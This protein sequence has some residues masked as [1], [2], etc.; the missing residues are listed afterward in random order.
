MDRIARAERLELVAD[1]LLEN[2][3]L[4]D[5]LAR[6]GLVTP[7]GSYVYG[8]MT[9]RDIDL[10][11][12]L[13]P[14]ELPVV[15]EIGR[16]IAALPGVGSML[17]RNEHVLETEGNPHAMF[18]R[19]TVRG[20][21]EADWTVEVLIAAPDEVARVVAPGER[22]VSE[23]TPESRAAILE[24]KSDPAY[25]VEFGSRDVHEAVLHHGLGSVE[26]L[27]A[28]WEGRRPGR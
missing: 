20:P 17:F 11:L 28:W 22:L 3:G 15:F 7:T 13:D 2:T 25:R 27:R 5:L 1:R 24:I 18:W 19:V 23:L 10:C 14:I 12:A 16:E 8:L 9:R 26:E 4:L 6:Y 21:D